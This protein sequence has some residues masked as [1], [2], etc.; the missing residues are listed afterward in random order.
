MPGSG[1]YTSGDIVLQ[2]LYNE[3]VRMVDMDANT[4]NPFRSLLCR[5]TTKEK[6]RITQRQQRFYKGSEGA[7][8]DHQ[9]LGWADMT[10]PDLAF[11]ELG[12]AA[13]ATAI[14][15]GMTAEEARD[16]AIDALGADFRLQQQL[17][18]EAVMTSG[19]F[20]DANM[21]VA[22]PPYKISTFATSHNHYTGVNQ[23]GVPTL[24]NITA[25]K[26]NIIEH[27]YGTTDN[28]GA[29]V[30]FL[31]SGNAESIENAA[32]WK[33]TSNYVGTPILETLQKSGLWPSGIA[34]AWMQAA[35]IPLIVEDWVPANYLVMLDLGVP[36]KM[37]RWRLPDTDPSFGI[38]TKGLIMETGADK[39]KWLITRYRRWGSCMVVHRGAGAVTYLSSAQSAY[40]SPTGFQTD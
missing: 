24:A 16:M 17:V 4:P 8:P 37:C 10:L 2:R 33:T 30:C 11:Y 7:S 14:E 26:H 3:I 39:F 38:N 12:S 19:A 40:V 29:L 27:G 36:D 28:G 15:Q 35:G 1:M 34:G 6:V 18:I 25:M 13:S 22:P 5:D 32:E 20:W 21:T 9:K 23:S 31:N